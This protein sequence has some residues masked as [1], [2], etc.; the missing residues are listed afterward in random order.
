MLIIYIYV[1]QIC[2]FC[3]NVL[4]GLF[5]IIAQLLK[6]KAFF[7]RFCF[8]HKNFILYMKNLRMYRI[9]LILGCWFNKKITL[10]FSSPGWYSYKTRKHLFQ[11][12]RVFHWNLISLSNDW[13][14]DTCEKLYAIWVII[15]NGFQF[16]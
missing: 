6:I 11:L 15:Q 13:A 8:F 12:K 1:L 4:I 10:K 16:S 7:F 14:L 3:I 5:V 2:S 9:F